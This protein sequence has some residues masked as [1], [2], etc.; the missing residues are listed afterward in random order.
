MFAKNDSPGPL[1]WFVIEQIRVGQS[2]S[3]IESSSNTQP[4]LA[5]FSGL[6]TDF[7]DEYTSGKCRLSSVK[8]L[9][10]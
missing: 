4:V 8:L 5:A 3:A 9:Q 7:D 1:G 10:A 6:G 2:V